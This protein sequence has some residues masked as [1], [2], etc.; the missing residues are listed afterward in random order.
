MRVYAKWKDAESELQQYVVTFNSM[1]GSAI[2]SIT[3]AEGSLL[4]NPTEPTYTGFIF[5]GWYKDEDC[6]VS[7]VFETDKV[8]SSITLYAGW[9]EENATTFTVTYKDGETCL[10]YTSLSLLKEIS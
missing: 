4:K 7:W 1:G 5:N 8:T 9:I 10:L 6:T 3:V 2:D